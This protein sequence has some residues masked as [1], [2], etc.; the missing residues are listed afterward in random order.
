MWHDINVLAICFA[1]INGLY[2]KDVKILIN[3]G[4]YV[5]YNVTLGRYRKLGQYCVY[6]GMVQATDLLVTLIFMN[7]SKKFL[8]RIRI[9][10]DASAVGRVRQRISVDVLQ[11]SI[12]AIVACVERGKG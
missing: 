9:A 1:G 6:L 5:R 12:G 10:V 11:S 3:S 7:E 8:Q 2:F 4:A